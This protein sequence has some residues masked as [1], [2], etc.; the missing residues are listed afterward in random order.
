MAR[1]S[2]KRYNEL[3][4]RLKAEGFTPRTMQATLGT[5]YSVIVFPQEL[6]RGGEIRTFKEVKEYIAKN[7]PTMTGR[8]NYSMY[9]AQLKSLYSELRG[10][11]TYNAYMNT[12]RRQYQRS[13]DIAFGAGKYN[14]RDYTLP[15][16]RDMMNEA[17]RSAREDPDG[18]ASFGEHLQQLLMQ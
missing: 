9:Q 1:V 2:I 11:R 17:W 18:S 12:K 10:E 15:E 16:I 7:F 6:K 3:V 4:R 14:V 13:I 8:Y 5:Y